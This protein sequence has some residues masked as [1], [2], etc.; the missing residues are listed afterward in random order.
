MHIN[1]IFCYCFF[2]KY[3]DMISVA[4]VDISTVFV[5]LISET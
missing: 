4:A 5:F 3:K 2:F 1:V